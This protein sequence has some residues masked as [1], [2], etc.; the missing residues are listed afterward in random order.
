MPRTAAEEAE[1]Q[2]INQQLGILP[3]VAP[4]PEGYGVLGYAGR[5]LANILPGAIEKT[6]QPMQALLGM[7]ERSQIPN[8]FDT[9]AP[10]SA[11]ENVIGGVGQI[12]QYLPAMIATEGAATTGLSTLGLSSAAAKVGGAALGWGLPMANEGAEQVG[13]QGGVGALQTAARLPGV[14]WKGKLAAGLIGGAAGYYEGAKDDTSPG[15][16]TQGAIMGG[17][18]LIA[19]TVI[20]PLVDKFFG[21]KPITV[22]PEIAQPRKIGLPID[23]TQGANI[24]G[25]GNQY[26]VFANI[27]RPNQ[28][29]IPE[30][31]ELSGGQPIIGQPAA[32]QLHPDLGVLRTDANFTYGQSANFYDVFAG[33]QR[34]PIITHNDL[35]PT[36]SSA[37]SFEPR[38]RLPDLYNGQLAIHDVFANIER[39]SS[40]AALSPLELLARSQFEAAKES[41]QIVPP[42][43]QQQLALAPKVKVV[44]QP[45]D[46]IPSGL[47]KILGPDVG[48]TTPGTPLNEG[49]T[50]DAFNLGQKLT[51]T[52]HIKWARTAAKAYEGEGLRLIETATSPAEIDKAME[53]V[54]RH[55]YFN[56]AAEYA[57][58][59][60]DKIDIFKQ[61]DPNY[62]PSIEPKQSPLDQLAAL[63]KDA[64]S[65]TPIRIKLGSSKPVPEI[66]N[67][68]HDAV[69]RKFRE[70]Q[71]EKP[72]PPQPEGPASGKAASP[73]LKDLQNLAKQHGVSIEEDKTNTTFYVHAPEG[74]GWD[75]GSLTSLVHPY[76]SHGSS[77]PEWRAEGIKDA[78]DRLY[79]M[80]APEQISLDATQKQHQVQIKGRFGSE[81]ANVISREGNTLHVEVN[82]PIFG[83][84]QT[85][86]LESD[87]QPVTSVQPKV[88]GSTV[89]FRDVESIKLTGQENIKGTLRSGEE[90]EMLGSI[91]EGG[92]PGNLKRK[93]RSTLSLE[94][95]LKKLPAEAADIIGT[96]IARLQEASGQKLDISLSRNMEG[97]AG[98]V[99][100]SSAKIKLNFTK[101]YNL[102]NN[103]EKL[104]SSMQTS[105]LLQITGTIGHEII[106]IAQIFGERSK[107]AIDGIPLL[108]AITHQVDSL[109]QVQRSYIIEQISKAKGKIN[110]TTNAYLA[111]DIEAVFNSYK[112]SRQGLTREKAKNLAAGEFMAEIGS[113]E[114]IKKMELQGLPLTLRS[115]INKFKTV[116]VNVLRYLKEKLGIV[117]ED[118]SL[119]ALQKI[120]NKILDHFA[121]ADISKLEEKFLGSE[122]YASHLFE[123][124]INAEPPMRVQNDLLLKSQLARL[125]VRA[126][127][128]GVAGGIIGPQVGPNQI[129]TAEGVMLGGI[130][131]I[132]GPAIAKR[133]LSGNFSKEIAEA[134][135]KSKGNPVKTFAAIMGH[136]S[137]RDMGLAARYGWTGESTFASKWVRWVEQNFDL[138]LDP[139]MKALVENGRGLGTLTGAIFQDAMD[140]IRWYKP[141]ASVENATLQFFT[142]KMTKEQYV[143]LM[144][145]PELQVY[146]QSAVTAREAMTTLTKM[147]A[148]GMSPS[149]FKDHLIKTSEEYLGRHYSAYREGKF[150]SDAF[151]RA[152]ADLMEKYK[153]YNSQI[154]DDI[155]REHMREVQANRSLFGGRRGNSGQKIDSSL[156]FRRLSTEE[157]IEGQKVVVGELEH[158]SNSAEYKAEKAKLD[159]MESHK[160]TDNWRDW[161]GEYKNPM[162]RMIYT[163]QK[164]HPSSISAKIFSM[165]DEHENS[166]GL[167]FS[168]TPTQLNQ[169]RELLKHGLTTPE[170]FQPEELAKIQIQLKE[171]SGYG[172][173]PEGNAYGLLSG[174]WVDRFTRDEINTYATP[175]KWAEQP[176]L[177][178]IATF[179]NVVKLT[180]APLN[181][182]TVLRNYVQMPL[183]ALIAKTSPRDIGEAFQQIHRVKGDDYKLMLE[184]HIIGVDFVSSEL[185]KGPGYLVSG[186][187]DSDIATKVAKYG[188]DKILKFYQQPDVIMRAGA[189]IS[190]R[191][192]FAQRAM[193]AA[194]ETFASLQ[195]AMKHSDVIDKAVEF[196]N[197]YTMNYAT[198]PR[199]VKIGRQ[200]PFINLFISYTSEITRILKN[201][202]SDAIS[203]TADSAGRMHALTVLGG[204]VAVPA[205]LTSMFEGSLSKKDQED[206]QKVKD[207]SP[208]YS[209]SRFRLPTSRDKEGRFHYFDITNYLPADALSQMVK[210]FSHGDYE[211]AQAANPLFSLQNTPLLNI[212]A[213]QIAGKDLQTDRTIEGVG[214]VREILKETLPPI[215][216]PG[217]E[218]TRLINAFSP[219]D[220]GGIGLTNAKTGVQYRPSDVIANYMTGMR[221]GNVELATVQKSAIGQAKQE[222]ALQ[223]SILRDIVN[224]NT[225][226]EQ[227]QRAQENYK[228]AEEE[229]MLKLN[230]KL[231][232]SN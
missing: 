173:L 210:A 136:E 135:T 57:E 158:D 101:I 171:L 93:D 95:G 50:K 205:M 60:P 14:G 227:K 229:I 209:R 98:S 30:K 12:A 216:P 165:L 47:Q 121:A 118:N 151:E 88:E 46:K 224:T 49:F 84:R 75:N 148:A 91:M 105:A 141:N 1:L 53:M 156:I 162:E 222:I 111:G 89:P 134:F 20:D 159:H 65:E 116:L 107:L 24:Y 74:K 34:P 92:G 45:H 182:L 131:G 183:F 41:T 221:F 179:N 181:P 146:G 188:I 117:S 76:G 26:D 207:L 78:Y 231:Q 191:R 25:N 102:V 22:L 13:V 85:S 10:Q 18:N 127:V 218:G 176:V 62:K 166:N 104:S 100:E 56:E 225:T 228:A 120:A 87:T 230:A 128:G 125:G 129:S 160:I 114:L 48:W 82:D 139:K 113:V 43:V 177:R 73:K 149:K 190:A 178:G 27:Q 80:G 180:H 169:V 217:Y 143:G 19:P 97:L 28:P 58:G 52:K 33:L 219:N 161:L 40:Q 226:P 4:Q 90:G 68:Q 130:A 15:I 185:S 199:I 223:Q 124:E 42:T 184:R 215:L 208:D 72:N 194:P 144:N 200:L 168:Y 204:M 112:K 108:K 202:T 54:S 133:L 21:P 39:Q 220:Q 126:A 29:F 154:A 103:W 115:A 86:I 189:F 232:R 106:H 11:T 170:K 6:I 35:F 71:G 163:F 55:Q 138:N 37:Q 150:N 140:K 186:H 23:P 96:I 77:L 198:V 79:E 110:P 175:F 193:E 38:M 31:K 142:G 157:E 36:V 145:T 51:T 8:F 99:D 195:D 5:T 132:F 167:K 94:E 211:A 201:L 137:L 119:A 7:S 9:R 63:Q 174:K 67:A 2:Q 81:I 59:M 187:L 196:T 212:A 70:S 64:T 147:Y 44:K 109:S 214:R 155:L 152:K 192:R 17:L 66:T 172:A 32:P 123:P 153:E 61:H 206:W 3:P 197:R 122:I 203:P 83:K 213:E 69:M 16:S 164:V